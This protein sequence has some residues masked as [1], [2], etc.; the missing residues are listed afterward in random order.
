[1]L[2]PCSWLPRCVCSRDDASTLHR[3]EPLAAPEDPEAV[4]VRLKAV[5][6]A[7]PRTTIVA[8][9]DAYV[10]AVCRTWL[11]F[12]DD[13]ECQLCVAAH[14]IHVRSASRIG[15]WD[16]GRNRRLVEA[17]RRLIGASHRNP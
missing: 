14:R 15:I 7:F 3:I 4:F 1:M 8:E 17:L 13:L 12:V 6:A 11:G 10:H 2:R 5:L 16:F 9:T